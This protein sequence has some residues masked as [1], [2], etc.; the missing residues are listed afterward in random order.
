VLDAWGWG[1]VRPLDRDLP[2]SRADIW[3]VL[4]VGEDLLAVEGWAE[5]GGDGNRPADGVVLT[6]RAPGSG[7]W[8]VFGKAE[9]H[10]LLA[11]RAW[12]GD[13]HFGAPK[14]SYSKLKNAA[15]WSG[16]VDIS[17]L[18]AGVLEVKAWAVDMAKRE[19]PGLK[20]T[21]RID[22]GELKPGAVLVDRARVARDD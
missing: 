17:A 1:D 4:V 9:S 11:P 3:R 13:G 8:T 15:G 22:R 5:F 10:P 2:K 14:P 18:P 20:S 19:A 7:A 21:F 6:Y 12:V 16:L